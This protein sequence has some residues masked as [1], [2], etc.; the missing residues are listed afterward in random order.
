MEHCSSTP[1]EQYF[2]KLT[3]DENEH[4]KKIFLNEPF[5]IDL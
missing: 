4:V 1:F 3:I 2:S 5:K